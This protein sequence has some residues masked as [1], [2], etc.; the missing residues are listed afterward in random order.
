MVATWK[1]CATCYP[2]G[3]LL[4]IMV[5]QYE[6]LVEI[7]AENHGLVRTE[8]AT[9]AGLARSNLHR[10]RVTGRVEEVSRGVYRVT[11]LPTDRL[12]TYMEAVLWAN[13]RGV[14]SHASALEMLELC[15][16]I[17]RRIHLT[18][19]R[20]YNPRKAGGEGYEVHRNDLP[21]EDLTIREGV[22]VVTAF[23]AIKQALGDGEDREQLRLAVRTATRE[24]L[25]LRSEAARLW[26]RL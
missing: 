9:G 23:R 2:H 24:G 5:T 6:A 26:A 3:N 13:G 4:C 17:P 15:D 14:I 18:V 25:L 16:I 11:A 8:D 21:A 19:P 1:W 12:T 22:P 7:A 20:A 10:L